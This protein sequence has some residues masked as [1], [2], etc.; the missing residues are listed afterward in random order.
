M[1]GYLELR[2]LIGLLERR[3]R[4][5]GDADL[6]ERD[7][8]GQLGQL[9]EVS[10]AIGGFHERHRAVIQPRLN[11]FLENCSYA[12]ALEWAEE[13]LTKVGSDDS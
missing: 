4:V 9:Q 3:M 2:E 11:H 13:S 7:P 12:K 8:A 1:L 6:R 5:I 10:E